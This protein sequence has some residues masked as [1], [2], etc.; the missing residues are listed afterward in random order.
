MKHAS[1]PWLKWFSRIALVGMLLT[2]VTADRMSEDIQARLSLR[3]KTKNLAFSALADNLYYAKHFG[4]WHC[5]KV[6]GPTIFDER[7]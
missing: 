4:I 3:Y 7:P 6:A 1:Y 5:V 2:L